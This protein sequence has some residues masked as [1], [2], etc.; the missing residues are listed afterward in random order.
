M[1]VHTVP[2]VPDPVM[3][4]VLAQICNDVVISWIAPTS[5]SRP[6]TGYSVS[7]SG[8]VIP[9]AADQTSHTHSFNDSVCDDTFEIGVFAIN[10]I[11]RSN[12]TSNSITIVCTRK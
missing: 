3:S 4:L 8:N 5:Q 10:A 6:I 9:V 12:V 7:I 2:D 11:G 1:Y